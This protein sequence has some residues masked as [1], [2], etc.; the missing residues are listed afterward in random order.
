MNWVHWALLSAF[1]AGITAVLAKAGTTNVEPNLATAVRTTV[2][3]LLAWGIVLTAGKPEWKTLSS[4]AT[5]YLVLSG[6]ATGLSWLCYFR[7]MHLGDASSVAPVEKLSV[8]FA[9]ALAALF[10]GEQLAWQHWVGGG[11]IIAGALLIATKCPPGS[12]PLTQ[13]PPPHT[14]R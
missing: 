14:T 11:L 10:L 1:F 13:D 8:V 2:V 3:L 12:S 4:Q 6:V 7:A 9:I 5:V